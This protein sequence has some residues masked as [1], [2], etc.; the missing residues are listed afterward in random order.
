MKL[1]KSQVDPSEEQFEAFFANINISKLSEGQVAQMEGAIT[2]GEI[3]DAIV[4]LKTGKS[5]GQD[6]LPVEYYRKHI[7]LLAPILTKVYKESFDKGQ[8]PDTYNEVLNT[9][10][11]KKDRDPADPGSYRPIHL[12]DVDGKILTKVLATRIERSMPYI[13][14]ADQVGFV[15]GHSSSD[16]VRRLLHLM[17]ASRDADMPTAALL[18]DVEKNV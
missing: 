17:W 13:V 2:E 18:L 12:I 10:I 6:E 7:D 9:L 1:Y 5:P 4:S 16:N 3:R 14:H 8:L 11:L 15:K